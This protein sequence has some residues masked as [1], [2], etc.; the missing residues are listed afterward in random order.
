MDEISLANRKAKL[1]AHLKSAREALY[2]NASTKDLQEMAEG[3]CNQL[4]RYCE[5]QEI[6][7]V[8]AY[9]PYGSEP[10]LRPFLEKLAR[11]SISV[12]LPVAKPD[13]QLHWVRWDGVS[14]SIGI[15]GFAEP[16]GPV[17]ELAEADLIILPASATDLLGNRL[18]KG[19]GYYDRALA[20][21]EEQ[22]RTAGSAMPL[23]VAVVYDSEVLAEI[24]AE[25][26]DR[27]VAAA[28]TATKTIK[29]DE[30]L[31]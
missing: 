8:A 5:G 6:A 27:K 16:I 3:F 14:T 29:F 22:R 11:D 13:R 24:P 26:H 20:S 4:V 17:A 28:I 2:A 15:H 21:L 10:E 7:T 1:R 19:L 9:L 12:L 30:G 31:N 18:G 25:S 23:T